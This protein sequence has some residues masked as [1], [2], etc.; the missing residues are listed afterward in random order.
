M[1]YLSI[2]F[3]VHPQPHFHFYLIDWTEKRNW[4]ILEWKSTFLFN[5]VGSILINWMLLWSFQFD[6]IQKV[7]TILKKILVNFNSNSNSDLKIEK[8]LLQQIPNFFVSVASPRQCW[9]PLIS[10]VHSTFHS[11]Y[12]KSYNQPKCCDQLSDHFALNKVC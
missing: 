12:P 6:R 5:L 1:S 4:R 7:K 3:P 9:I 10:A 11:Q 2:G 8:I